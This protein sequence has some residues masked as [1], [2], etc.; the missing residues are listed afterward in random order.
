V[1]P[2]SLTKETQR[3]LKV[4]R[5][6]PNKPGLRQELRR[7]LRESRV[8]ERKLERARRLYQVYVP[9]G[10]TVPSVRFDLTTRQLPAVA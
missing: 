10:R 8:L 2:V 1:P 9:D 6:A 3:G 4:S 7:R 5:P